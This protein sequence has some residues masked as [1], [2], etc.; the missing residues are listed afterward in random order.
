[1]SKR[2]LFWGNAS[3]KLGEAVFYRAGGEQR[4]RTWI[5]KIKNPKTLSQVENRLSLLNLVTTYKEWKDIISKAFPLKKKNQSDYN[6]LV[7]RNKNTFT[8]VIP[9][10]LASAGLSMPDGMI[11]TDGDIPLFISAKITEDIETG[12][13]GKTA[14]TATGLSFSNDELPYATWKRLLDLDGNMTGADLY[15]VLVG[16]DN[17]MNLPTLFKVFC[18][19]GSVQEVESPAGAPELAGVTKNYA[20]IECSPTSTDEIHYVGSGPSATFI[21]APNVMPTEGK[22]AHASAFIF[23]T[24]YDTSEDIPT[25]VY[26]MFIS[27]T[28]DSKQHVTTSQLFGVDGI[29]AGF[30]AEFKKGGIIYD[31]AL[32]EMGYNP[33]SILAT[34]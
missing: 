23:D 31:Y 17:P 14:V 13:N 2:S 7:S 6:A 19:I 20:Y 5:P 8:S 24:G 3:G 21:I 27:Y 29:N 28:A 30:F 11:L 15:S 33:D 4:T 12:G 16:S 18:C 32:Q 26:T 34:K 22:T 9:K 10:E 1:M 25:G